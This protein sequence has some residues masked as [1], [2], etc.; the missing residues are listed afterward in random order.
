[1]NQAIRNGVAVLLTCGVI[2]CLSLLFFE[3]HETPKLRI[4][5]GKPGLLPHARG[6]PSRA[7]YGRLRWKNILGCLP[8]TIN[9]TNSDLILFIHNPT[10]SRESE[11]VFV[12]IDT[13]RGIVYQST[14]FTGALLGPCPSNTISSASIAEDKIRYDEFY[15]GIIYHYEA[16]I[17]NTNFV[18][19][20]TEKSMR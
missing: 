12:A 16:R 19:H 17:L 9:V 3:R 7:T 13:N 6:R 18:M 1:M 15:H 20:S 10:V 11:H 4:E 14:M 5:A 8:Y 2:L